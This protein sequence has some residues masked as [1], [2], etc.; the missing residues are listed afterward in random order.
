MNAALLSSALPAVVK[1]KARPSLTVSGIEDVYIA[2]TTATATPAQVAAVQAY[3]DEQSGQVDYANVAAAAA[4]AVAV[5]GTIRCRRGTTAA[6]KSAADLAW[7]KYIAALALGGEQPDGLVELLALENAMHDA[8]AFNAT[9]LT[10]NGT[11][12]D[13]VLTAFQCATLD[14]SAGLPSQGMTWQEIA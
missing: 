12:A 8:G 3:L 14:E 11:A 13:L 7:I 9:G 5:G 1:V 2:G 6:V 10:L 4:V